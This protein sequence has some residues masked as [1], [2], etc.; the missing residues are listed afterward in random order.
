M[1]KKKKMKSW[2]V[3]LIV[4]LALLLT[5]GLAGF[6]VAN[7][8]LSK[9]NYE[10]DTTEQVDPSA[11][12]KIELPAEDAE[13]DEEIKKNIDDNV[14]WYNKNVMNILLIGADKGYV[15]QGINPRS[16]A[17]IILSI[18]K[19]NHQIRLASVLRAAY[20]SIP[21]HGHSRLNG[22]HS[23]GGPR[24]LIKTIEQNY[25]IH[26]DNY[27]SV[28][29]NAFQK[30]ID[31]LG[32]VDIKLTDEEAKFL[33]SVF[34]DSE[35][36]IPK[37]AGTCHMNGEV[38]LQY[39]RLRS[40]DYDRIRTQRQRNVLTQIANKAKTMSANQ[41]MQLL[42]EILPLVTT[43]LTKTKIVNHMM[44]GLNYIRWPITQDT[45]PHA[46][47]KKL[48]FVP[49]YSQEV[50]LLDWAE[51]K[52]DAHAFLYPNMEPQPVPER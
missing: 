42:D 28:D 45:I 48:V 44:N 43:D 15:N 10:V 29:F 4:I 27:I 46:G 12:E 50:L 16:D 49:G 19:Q 5:L 3:V 39:V 18:D 51:T 41:A 36:N 14:M 40:I 20:V 9:F 2:V 21:G 33:S 37:T 26:I 1:S 52:R 11:F 35:Y 24:L 34:A 6:F 32:G 31:I 8:Y 23:V 47:P 38:A 7:H 22:A 25:K 17:M 13:A 30:V